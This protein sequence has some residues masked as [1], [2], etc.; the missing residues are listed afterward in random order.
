M[1]PLRIGLRSPPPPTRTHAR[2][3]CT[4]KQLGG[5]GDASLPEWGCTPCRQPPLPFTR[6]ISLSIHACPPNTN[7]ENSAKPN[8]QCHPDEGLR[9]P[10]PFHNC[11][12]TSEERRTQ[13]RC[14]V[15]GTPPPAVPRLRH[16]A[17]RD[18]RSPL[19]PSH[20][21]PA[22]HPPPRQTHNPTGPPSGTVTCS[23]KSP[24]RSPLRSGP[25]HQ[26][27]R[28]GFSE[29]VNLTL[30]PPDGSVPQARLHRGGKNKNVR[31]ERR[32]SAVGKVQSCDRSGASDPASS[33]APIPPRPPRP[34]G[35]PGTEGGCSLSRRQTSPR[36]RG[37]AR[38]HTH[39][40][41][42][43]LPQTQSVA[44]G[45]RGSVKTL[46]GCRDRSS[47]R[48]RAAT[49]SHAP[50]LRRIQSEQ[51]RVW[52][53]PEPVQQMRASKQKG[54]E[55]RS[56]ARFL[57]PGRNPAHDSGYRA[58]PTRAGLQPCAPFTPHQESPPPPWSS[59]ATA[60]LP[61]GNPADK[62]QTWGGGE[63]S[64]CGPQQRR[65]RRMGADAWLPR[66]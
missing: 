28:A 9:P 41:T 65:G 25:G 57:P 37:R 42:R 26:L 8:S 38:T 45:Q 2:A 50:Y 47:L 59:R 12:L 21:P 4:H 52:P 6:R 39:T 34:A 40:H 56:L 36:P 13:L 35:S 7:P 15:P 54:E 10:S 1:P 14:A 18:T 46:P 55:S 11:H 61:A 44:G 5:G 63:I 27:P 32:I 51:L 23:L 62:G 31:K 20:R 48:P 53:V 49:R 66:A 24:S 3:V 16:T 64:E 19:Q 17:L 33:S 43:P 29:P 60:P 58:A 30:T 22:R